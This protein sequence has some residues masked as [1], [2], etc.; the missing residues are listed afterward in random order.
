MQYGYFCLIPLSP[1]EVQ[2]RLTVPILILFAGLNFSLRMDL[3]LLPK[4]ASF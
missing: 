1:G 3:W 2:V 4:Y